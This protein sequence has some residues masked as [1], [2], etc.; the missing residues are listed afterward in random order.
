M[1]KTPLPGLIIIKAPSS[2]TPMPIM[3]LGPIFS[4]K[5]KKA[6]KVI[7]TGLI[8]NKAVASAKP[9]REK[10]KKNNVVASI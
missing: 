3:R 10:A 7:S 8:L 1:V 4:F 9:N 6:P 2:E 5:N